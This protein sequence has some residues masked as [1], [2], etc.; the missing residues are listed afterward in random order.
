MYRW[1]LQKNYGLTVTEL[2]IVI[3]HPNNENYQIFK[4][5]ILDDEIEAMLDCR[6]R[7][8]ASGLNATVEFPQT[9]CLLE[10]D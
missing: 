4:L 6:K 3:F 2:C 5:N 1:F 10:D 7:A 8:I 9:E